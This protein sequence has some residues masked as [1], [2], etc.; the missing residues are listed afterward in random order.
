ML[1]VIFALGIAPKSVFHDALVH[2]RDGAVCQHPDKQDPCVH[3][4][5]F[6]CGFDDLVVTAPF[7]SL[8]HE[9]AV[10]TP[11][12]FPERSAF[13]HTVYISTNRLRKEGRGPPLA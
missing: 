12:F 10:R 9:L 6:H 2:H 3:R 1:L 13:F 11:E 4:Q 8:S 7:V 5:A